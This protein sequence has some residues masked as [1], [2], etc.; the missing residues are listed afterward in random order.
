MRDGRLDKFTGGIERAAAVLI[1]VLTL[2][3]VLGLTV[4]AYLGTSILNMDDVSGENIEF[5]EDNIFLN[6][7]LLVLFLSA[8]YLFYRHS[9]HIRIRR[10]ECLLLVWVLCFGT[11]F[12]ASTKLRAPVYSDSF[13][14]TYGAQRAALGDYD[15]L[16]ENYFFR[17]PFQLGYALVVLDDE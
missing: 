12:I 2:A 15:A 16:C 13:I 9:D 10:M 4:S 14:V 11:A 17:F 7:I 3:F 1:L 5:Y 6:L 8:L